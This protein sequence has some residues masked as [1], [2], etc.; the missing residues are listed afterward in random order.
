MRIDSTWLATLCLSAL[1]LLIGTSGANAQ[2]PHAAPPSVLE[3]AVQQHV[4][5]TEADRQMVLRLLERE[6]VKAIAGQ[7]GLDLKTAKSAVATMGAEELEAVTAQAR[8]ADRALAGGQNLRINAFWVII[9]L[10]IIILIVVA[11]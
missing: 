3:S 4:A 2:T 1:W 5:A 8:V 9:G 6:E 7:A 11:K 10:L